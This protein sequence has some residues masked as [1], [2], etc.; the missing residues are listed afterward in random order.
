MRV[1]SSL[2]FVLFLLVAPLFASSEVFGAAGRANC[3][4]FSPAEVKSSDQ[5]INFTMGPTEPGKR[6]TI[7][8]DINKDPACRVNVESPQ[9]TATSNSISHT[10]TPANEECYRKLVLVAPDNVNLIDLKEFGASAPLCTS[11][12]LTQS[13]CALDFSPRKL[14]VGQTIT[15]TGKNLPPARNYALKISG[16]YSQIIDITPQNGTF[17]QEMTLGLPSIGRYRVDVIDRSQCEPFCQDRPST[18]ACPALSLKVGPPGKPVENKPGQNIPTRNAMN[19][20]ECALPEL[21]G[22]GIRT[23]IG[24]IPTKD[25][26]AFAGWFLRWAVGLGGGIAFLMIVFSAFQIMT[27]GNNPQQLQG[28]RELLTAAISGL[29]LIIFSVF[30]LRLIGVQILNIPGFG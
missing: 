27:A 8:V 6:Y 18:L 23:A 11:Q 4:P 15:I 2:G 24:C 5:S 20:N 10:F 28:G 21:G 30:L 14:E 17:T 1:L 26:N 7:V 19:P 3:S 22:V 16:A 13:T 9:I 25:A 29:I 12:Y